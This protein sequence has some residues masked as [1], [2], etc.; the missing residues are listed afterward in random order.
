MLRGP[1]K[2]NEYRKVILPLTV[3]RRFDCV[4]APTK[5]KVL[6]RFN[7][8]KG[9]SENIIRPECAFN[10][11]LANPPFGVEWKQQQRFIEKER[12]TLGYEGRFGVGLPRI[13]D[14]ALLFLQHMIS[15]MNRPEDGGS[16]IAIVFNGS[17][18][19]T[20]DAGQG[21]SEIRRWIIEN[22][23]LEA[24]VAL[25]EQLFYNTGISTY[26]RVVTNHKEKRRRG[27]V[28]LIDARE[29]YKDMKKSLGKK[30]REIGNGEDG[31]PDQIAEITKIYDRFKHNDKHRIKTGDGNHKEIIV[32]KVFDNEDF[33]YHKITVEQPLRL[34]FQA[35]KERIVRLE[36][37]AGFTGLVK[38]KK[39]KEDERLREIE[40]GKKRQEVIRK[41]LQK[42][43]NTKCY[44]DRREF[45]RD[46]REL[47][48]K[49]DVRLTATELKAVVNALSE[50]DDTAE[51]CTDK[52]GNP[53]PDT[54]LRDTENI[55]LNETIEAYFAREV[56]PYVPDAWID[57][58]KTRVGYE[59]PLTRHFYVYEPPR[60][61]EEIEKDIQAIE[62]DILKLFKDITR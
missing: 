7:E 23:W 26:V 13:N 17:P 47:D 52:H 48:R 9:K 24:I 43:D 53:E 62:G 1:Y 21:E 33:G 57:Y 50:R 3:L 5:E 11:M 58:D 2:R 18:L 25:P 34:D 10:Y 37:E 15:K 41:L 40:A 61:L 22:D 55:P 56:K 20:G 14:G 54:Q 49:H 16:R 28:Q 44:K 51:I 30:R 35:N 45:L 60:R 8:L 31:K 19:F 42:M 12:N 6:A 29:F 59:I 39:K 38:P 32:S 46:L 36:E 4:L 27:K